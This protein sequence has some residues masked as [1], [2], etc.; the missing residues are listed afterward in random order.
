MDVMLWWPSGTGCSA[1]ICLFSYWLL[2]ILIFYLLKNMYQPF[3]QVCVSKALL[4]KNNLRHISVELD[5]G[6]IGSGGGC[7]NGAN[8][9]AFFYML[10]N[11]FEYKLLTAT[12]IC[13]EAL[14]ETVA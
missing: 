12:P 5:G 14:S 13:I 2:V 3:I 6:G 8:K 1:K 10:P 4:L 7:H 11:G 9:N